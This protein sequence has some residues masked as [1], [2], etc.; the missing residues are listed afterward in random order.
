VKKNKRQR[1][2]AD[3]EN[4]DLGN[5]QDE[6]DELLDATT[7]LV[8]PLLHA[9]DALQQAGRLMHPPTLA[10]VV[11]AIAQYQA[12]LE[13]GRQAFTAVQ[14]P[15]HLETFT[16]HANMATTLALRAFDGFAQAMEKPE[17]AMAA[18]KAMGLATQAYAAAYPL[19]TML[20]PVS[21]FY[22]EPDVRDDAALQQKL[23]DVDPLTP[24]VGVMH[25]ENA[26]EQRGGFSMYV[27]EY[28]Q[29]ETLPLV[30]ALHGGSGHGRQ[31]L[32][33]WLR[34]VR[35][36]PCI[37]IAPT[38]S[39]RT[40]SLMNPAT[41]SQRLHDLVAYAGEHWSIDPQRILLTGMSDGGTFS[42]VS[43][44][45]SDSPFTHLAPCSASFHPMLLEVV[46][47][48]RLQDLPIYLMHGALDWMFPVSVAQEA[49]VALSSAGAKVEYREIANLSHTY[50]QEENPRIL[51][52]LLN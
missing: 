16:L 47:S 28:Y 48:T 4:G 7:G 27:P 2:V 18:Y 38:S 51:N 23:M 33:S 26:S 45:Q 34:A 37:L 50:P 15:E 11:E 13:A 20:P 49:N 1:T 22:L 39:E 3:Q 43:G 25:A 44:L 17:P 42:Y 9:L 30:V 21:R 8:L 31:F 36:N 14:W 5:T 52:W 10:E 35:S 40:W 29:G 19:A 6:T 32:W 24:N 12:P 46:D 41:D